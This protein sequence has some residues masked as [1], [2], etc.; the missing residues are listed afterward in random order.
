MRLR[1]IKEK[2]THLPGNWLRSGGVV[3]LGEWSSWWEWAG[4]EYWLT[5]GD[6]LK[7]V[8]VLFKVGVQ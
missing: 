3:L 2:L 5:G 7:Q 1:Y 6:I 4:G 8:V